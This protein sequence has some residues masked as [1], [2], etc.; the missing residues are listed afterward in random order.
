MTNNYEIVS[1]GQNCLP[2]LYCT[3]NFLKKTK[4]MGEL[5]IPFDLAG[6]RLKAIIHFLENDFEDYFNDLQYMETMEIS[7]WFN[8]KFDCQYNHDRDCGKNDYD[9][10]VTRF[11]SRIENF[12]KIINSD[13]FI[14]FILA[15]FE[16]KTEDI[17]QLYET[18][19]K[20]RGE[21]PF[22]LIV[23]DFTFSLDDN[24]N[25]E[26]S[27]YTSKYQIKELEDWYAWDNKSEKT[28]QVEN[29]F[30]D[31]VKDEIQKFFKV[32]IYKPNFFD[33][34]NPSMYYLRKFVQNIFSVTNVDEKHKMISI[35]GIKFK[36]KKYL[37]QVLLKSKNN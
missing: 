5:S 22:K 10:F 30:I 6:H 14:F 29:N 13:K 34:N 12:R 28:K 15:S 25:K 32:E 4:K 2:R 16:N 17:N 8:S 3:R 23:A 37:K 31:F 19:K 36:I 24:I 35:F 33:Y 26:V 11:K 9:K 20:I 18:L 1:L 7:C 27:I 21:K